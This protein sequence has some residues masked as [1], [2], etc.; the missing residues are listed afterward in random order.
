MISL[1][2]TPEELDLLREILET[3][4]KEMTLEIA[5]TDSSKFKTMLKEKQ[6]ILNDLLVKLTK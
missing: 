1:K 6:H 4:R 5:H 3:H 2:L